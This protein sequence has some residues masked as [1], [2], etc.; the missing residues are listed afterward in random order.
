[1]E[2]LK[3]LFESGALTWEQFSQAVTQKGYK[4]ADLATGNY[5]S[6]SKYNDDLAGKDATITEL[7]GQIATRDAD[8]E[9]LKGKLESA[10]TDNKTKVA[11]LTSQITKLQGDYDTARTDYE[12]KLS[13]QAYEFAVREFA[14]SKQFTSNAAK[15]DFINEMIK[16]SL[17]MKDNTLL[18]ADDF[19]KAYSEANADAFVVEKPSEEPPAP[20]FVNPS[21]PTPPPS[22]N[23]FLD[24]FNFGG[25]R[26]KPN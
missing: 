18:G 17:K 21:T 12:T 7:N 16:E 20:T 19:V 22:D 23:A 1:M 10:G 11:E 24:A 15:R 4:L 6:K 2:F 14:N 3:A 13:Q 25:V 5:V 8:L 9:E 26:K